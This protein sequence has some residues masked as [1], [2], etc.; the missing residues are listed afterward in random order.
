MSKVR[1]DFLN[2]S[3]DL[4]DFENPLIEAKNALHQPEGWIPAKSMT[5]GA[6]S[7]VIDAGIV[8]AIVRPIGVKNQAVAAVLKNG[9]SAGNGFTMD[10]EITLLA[11]TNGDYTKQALGGSGFGFTSVT[12]NTVSTVGTLNNVVAFDVAE[13]IDAS[14][15]RV[16]F[17]V[18]RM[19]GHR[20]TTSASSVA[21][22]WSAMAASSIGGVGLTGWTTLTST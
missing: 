12:S 18:A 10:L 20:A 9:Q 21:P 17:F 15:D 16:L 3:P 5:A 13:S 7:T 6:K 11:E 1:L 19:E 4:D 22:D 8:S 2:W 14:G